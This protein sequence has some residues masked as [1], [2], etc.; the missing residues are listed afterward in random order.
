MKG[1]FMKY[2]LG[3]I[4]VLTL[5]LASC[6]ADTA[7][8]QTDVEAV[9]QQASDMQGAGNDEDA[10]D[11]V[12]DDGVGEGDNTGNDAQDEVVVGETDAEEQAMVFEVVPVPLVDLGNNWFQPSNP[13]D[14]DLSTGEYQLIEFSAFW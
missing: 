11:E 9:I 10:V 5:L 12:V 8:L 1:V 6:Q 4:V 13:L 2:K 14:V 3:I 7:I